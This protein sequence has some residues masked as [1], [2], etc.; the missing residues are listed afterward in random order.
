MGWK[1]R[2]VFSRV[3]KK[4][5]LSLTSDRDDL[6]KFF[7]RAKREN[8]LHFF[9]EE[10]PHDGNAQFVRNE[11]TPRDKSGRP[12]I[13]S[14]EETSPQQFVIGNAET[15]LELSVE[16][17][18]L[19]N[20]ENDQVRKR[21]ERISNVTENGGRRFTIWGMCVTVKMESA[22]STKKRLKL[23]FALLFL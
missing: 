4:L 16:S 12:D 8:R 15:K 21:H 10:T 1:P 18:S 2:F 6:I 9:H 23:F 11:E 7:W 13:D 22:V 14:Q 20:R 3:K 19:M 5:I 17:R